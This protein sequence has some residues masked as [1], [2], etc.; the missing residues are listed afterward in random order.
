MALTE[1]TKVQIARRIAAELQDDWVV[2]VGTGMP[3]AV[4]KCVPDE[5]DIIF[6]S[7]NGIVGMGPE[8]T[9]PAQID[10]DLQSA[11][12]RPVTLMPGGCFVHHR[13]SFAI[14]RGG[15]LD[16]AILGGYQVAENG[17]LANWKLPGAKLGSIGGAMDI[18]VGAKRVFIMMTHTT[19][20][21]KPK[22]VRSLNYPLTA[23]RCVTKIFTELAVIAVTA[24]GLVLETLAPGVSLETVQKLTEPKLILGKGLG[25]PG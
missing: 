12:K 24:A 7:E 16:A 18:C 23:S 8:P 1:D 19:P 22:I 11:G 6:H 14:A 21:G 2:N 10:T 15:M 20:D 25:L 13:D 9:D 17:D 3:T 5:R 4:L